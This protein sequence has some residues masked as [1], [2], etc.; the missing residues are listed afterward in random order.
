MG[1]TTTT[2]ASV[3]IKKEKKTKKKTTKKKKRGPGRPRKIIQKDDNEEG[4]T[5]S[6]SGDDPM[7]IETTDSDVSITM[8]PPQPLPSSSSTVAAAAVESAPHAPTNNNQ[9]T[10]TNQVLTLQQVLLSNPKYLHSRYSTRQLLTKY[11]PKLPL[12][13][14]EQ[15]LDVFEK[16]TGLGFPILL[17]EAKVEVCQR[18][19]QLVHIFGPLYDRERKMIEEDDEVYLKRWIDTDVKQTNDGKSPTNKQGGNEPSSTTTQPSSKQQYPTIAPP[20][21]LS[22]VITQVYNYWIHKR[23]I[24]LKKPLL[25][26]YQ[27]PTSASDPDPKKVFRQRD[28]ESK[29]R[30]RK[31]KQNDIEAYTKMKM[32]KHDFE[33]VR[34]L[35]DLIIQREQVNGLNVELTNEYFEERMYDLL[36]T[37]G[38]PRRKSQRI[39]SRQQQ[40]GSQQQ[41]VLTKDMIESVLNN[42][43]KYFDDSPIVR[44]KGNKKRK[45]SSHVGWNPGLD[46]RDPSPLPPQMMMN[47]GMMMPSS[48]PQG[49]KPPPT[50]VLTSVIPTPKEVVV[51]GHDSGIPAPNFLQPLASRE[52]HHISSTQDETVPSMPSYVNGRSTVHPTKFRHRPRL[53]RGGRIIIDR[54]PFQSSSSITNCDPP[55]VIT[56]G[57]PMNRS[58]YNATTLGA[59]GPNYSINSSPNKLCNPNNSERRGTNA[60]TGLKVPPAQ[61]LSDLLPKP[62]DNTNNVLSRKIEEICA[63]GL[64]EDYQNNQK[65]KAASSSA[66]SSS[67]SSTKNGNATSSAAASTAYEGED[68]HEVLVPI[69]DWL[70]APES[71]K[72]Y[73]SE[74]FVI[75]PL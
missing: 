52:T 24:I 68:V 29:R 64:L 11:N 61:Q 49:M 31:K 25:R 33:Q 54:V 43:P 67:V 70:E 63:M 41:R 38:E 26:R 66:V 5:T 74:K 47:Q 3:P 12:S 55:T 2:K 22:Q 15:M 48:L 56:Y 50:A 73:G 58:G 18:I 14:F 6:Q 75:G 44:V 62:V 8:V 59:D 57:T 53:G 28:K 21:T 40:R 4:A 42:I 19:P 9:T 27:T 1:E 39:G 30:L 13:I 71:L 36:D 34:V 37:S 69:E 45:R 23:D 7:D 35:C 16:T 17:E 51:A 32:L 20:I 65:S 72:I 46:S 10:K 60:K